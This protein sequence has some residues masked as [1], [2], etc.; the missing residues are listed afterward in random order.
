MDIAPFSPPAACTAKQPPANAKIA[1]KHPGYP[2]DN[3][4]NII[5]QFPCFDQD[6]TGKWGLHRGTLTTIAFILCGN[7]PGRLV[8]SNSSNAPTGDDSDDNEVLVNPSYY[9]IPDNW[10]LQIEGPYSIVRS[11]RDYQFPHSGLPRSWASIFPDEYNT[12]DFPPSQYS[13]AVRARDATCR[14]TGSGDGLEAAHIV[15]KAEREWFRRNTMRVY[16]DNQSLSPHHQLNDQRNCLLLRSD[17]HQ[18][19]NDRRSFVFVPK[20]GKIVN[21]FVTK[22]HDLG[23]LYHNRELGVL[24][25]P[26]EFIFARLAWAII[27]MSIAFTTTEGRRI[28]IFDAETHSYKDVTYDVPAGRYRGLPGMQSHDAR[29]E[30][31][32]SDD[33]MSDS[34]DIE[35]R[36]EAEDEEEARL[37]AVFHT[38]SPEARYNAGYYPGVLEMERLKEEYL[39]RHEGQLH[40]QEMKRHTA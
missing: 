12:L 15:P 35:N 11:F 19:F 24:Q 10:S 8:P 25:V 38:L 4:Q 22:T 3:L 6:S 34:D 29:E 27:P 20:A 1:L 28:K 30:Q 37:N 14:V 13:P 2:D 23:S 21:H 17:V 33:V 26:A 36:S 32:S 39:R 40:E 9:Y 5:A 18:V 7:R 16:N 31:K